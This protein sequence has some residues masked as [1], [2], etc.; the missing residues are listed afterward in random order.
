MKFNL[1]NTETTTET[2]EILLN[3]S[4]LENFHSFIMRKETSSSLL[5]NSPETSL[6]ERKGDFKT[7]S[8]ACRESL[9]PPLPNDRP[10][11][12]KMVAKPEKQ[13]LR[14]LQLLRLLHSRS[15]H[16]RDTTPS[17]PRQLEKQYKIINLNEF[18]ECTLARDN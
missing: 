14:V 7:I 2:Y 12:P 5:L 16:N 13:H 8:N 18:Q 11:K 6:M 15:L 17:A 1:P 4:N 3:S 10:L 9:K